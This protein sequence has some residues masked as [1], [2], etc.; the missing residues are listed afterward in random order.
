M[1]SFLLTRDVPSFAVSSL[2][3]VIRL[4]KS[5]CLLGKSN[6][7]D[8]MSRKHP[9]FTNIIRTNY[10]SET[11]DGLLREDCDVALAGTDA[12]NVFQR[13]EIPIDGTPDDR[14]KLVWV[15]RSLEI[16]PSGFATTIDTGRFCT[17]LI[18]YVLDLHMHEMKE[19]GFLGETREKFY[20]KLGPNQCVDTGTDQNSSEEDPDPLG[21][22]DMFGI[23]SFHALCSVISVLLAFG[24]SLR[25]DLME[26]TESM[27]RL[28]IA[29]AEVTE[30][31]TSFIWEPR[32]P[33]AAGRPVPLSEPS[34]I[35]TPRRP[36]A[37]DRRASGA[38]ATSNLRNRT[39]RTT[40]PSKGQR[41]RSISWKA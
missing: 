5:V 25:K 4:D 36:I 37:A 10:E 40:S 41:G 7:D 20:E 12:F 21:M 14:C 33:I 29:V 13:Q 28:N 1:A 11:F 2:E 8:Y 9:S 38:G 39:H 15:G 27:R 31:R 16:T 17:S 30:T 35:W 3:D 23:F 34:S 32:Q 26:R 24:L 19:D 18:S 6:H 22:N